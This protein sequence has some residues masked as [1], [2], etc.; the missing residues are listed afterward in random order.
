MPLR[1][2]GKALLPIL[3]I[4]AA[5]AGSCNK[6][7][8]GGTPPPT[9]AI[10]TYDVDALGI[11]RFIS[12][13]YI[14]LAKIGR[15][16]KFRSSEGHSYTDGFELCRSMK[17][18]FEPKAT[19][20]WSGVKIMSPVKGTVSRVFEEWAGT[21]VHIR[22]DQYPAFI[23]IIFHIKLPAPSKVGDQITLGQELEMH[24]GGQTMS[25]IAVEVNTPKGRRLISYLD[26]L[27]DAL[28][29][30]YQARGLTSRN[31]A[32][33][34]KEARDAEPLTCSGEVFVTR[35][36]LENWVILN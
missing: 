17:H 21:Q 25:D 1:I 8:D 4:L 6:S 12:V 23:L 34:T 33:I 16:S 28:F 27:T 7:D 26:V 15:I 32:I 5:L 3:L 35:G 24:V 22:S 14:E 36:T 13:D 9:T 29:Q 31:T 11:P 19:I 18:Y 2:T 30:S 10:E 20:D